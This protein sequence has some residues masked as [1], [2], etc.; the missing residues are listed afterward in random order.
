M[1]KIFEQEYMPVDGRQ[2]THLMH[3]DGKYKKLSLF[4]SDWGL[5]L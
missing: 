2:L 1:T 3:K 4:G 5:N